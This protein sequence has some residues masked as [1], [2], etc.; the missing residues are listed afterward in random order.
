MRSR[1][2]RRTRARSETKEMR[3]MHRELTARGIADRIVKVNMAVAPGSAFFWEALKRQIAAREF[4]TP[5]RDLEVVRGIAMKI[6]LAE[7]LDLDGIVLKL[8]WRPP[9][10][11]IE[12][13]ADQ[14]VAVEVVEAIRARAAG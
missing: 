6:L 10:L 12:A 3:A 8:E 5:I 2:E 14:C 13:Q 1:T 11:W 4:L 9:A 7:G